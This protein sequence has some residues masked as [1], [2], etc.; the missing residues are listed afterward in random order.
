[1]YQNLLGNG[2]GKSISKLFTDHG[3]NIKEQLDT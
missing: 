3:K 1:M 2:S